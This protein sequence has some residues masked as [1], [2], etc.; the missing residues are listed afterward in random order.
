MKA[1]IL[2]AGLGTRLKPFTDKHPKALAIVNG[3]TLLQIN[4]EYLKK[5]GIKDIIVNVHHFASQITEKN[6]KNNSFGINIS[7]SDETNEV[8]ETGGGIKNAAWFFNDEKSFLVMNVDILTKMNLQKMIDIHTQ[9]NPIATLA[10]RDRNSSRCL[11]LN[12]KNELCGWRNKNTQ[13]ERISRME[14]DLIEKS[15]SGIHLLKPTI[16]EH[17]TQTGKFS[18]IDSYLE[19]AKTNIIQCADHT[20]E[21]LMDVGKPES[22][23]EAE[24]Y[25]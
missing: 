12:Y 18:I 15:F 10:V 4:I 5:Y 11:L 25:F 14:K 3:K 24:K 17:I 7:I 22:I 19:I 6:K 8:L 16:F 1:M 13:E 21:L 2:A 9:N 20:G 23:L